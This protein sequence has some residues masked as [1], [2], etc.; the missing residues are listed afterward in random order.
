[1][2]N[3]GNLMPVPAKIS[4]EPGKLRITKQFKIAVQG[5]VSPRLTSG[6]LRMLQR[7]SGR[8][9]L[10]VDQKEVSN[11]MNDSGAELQISCQREGR[12]ELHEDEFYTLKVTAEKAFLSAATDLGVIRGMESF[13]Q[14]LDCDD[15]GFF[16]PAVT[17]ADFPRFPW[18]GLMIDCS[19]HFQPLEVIRR[20]LD[21]MA[22]VKLNVFHWHLSD[23]QGFRVESR[24]CPKLH[25]MGSDQLY[26]TQEQ[27]REII[28]YA[29]ERGIRVV[30][31]FD[32]PGHCTSW[33]VGYPE[34]GSTFQE[35]HIA[36]RYKIFANSIN[37]AK[38]ATYQFLDTFF[39]EMASLFPDDYIHIGG[40]E[41]TDEQWDKDPEIVKFK[42]SNGLETKS[43]LQVYFQNRLGEI[44]AKHHKKMMGWD[45]IL[46]PKLAESSVIESWR[47]KE[48]LVSAVQAGFPCVLANGYYIDL[49]QSAEYHY[50]N[51]PCP[52]KSS[53]NDAQKALILGG[54]AAMWSEY[55]S[56]ENIDSRIWPRTA[57]I[58]ERF[59]SPCDVT[60]VDDMYRRLDTVS[61]HLEELG[62]THEK[63]YLMFLR[64]LAGSYDI[65][66][67][68]NLADVVEPVKEYARHI[69]SQHTTFSPLTR[70]V[71]AA[72]PDAKIA[73]DFRRLIHQM[74]AGTPPDQNKL[75]EAKA[76]LTLWENNH[77][78]LQQTICKAP[79]LKEIADL[80]ADLAKIAAIGLEGLSLIEN[81]KRASKEWVEAKTIFLDEAEKPRGEVELMVVSAVR[82]I[83]RKAG[84]CP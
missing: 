81:Q 69:N 42:K 79:A 48:H 15:Q 38:E 66:A 31:E 70:M 73:R 26:Y 10:F 36:D 49:L 80:A 5:I 27:I 58:A 52:E 34:L 68:K 62:L 12:V 59:W 17:I 37:P 82:Q 43:D 46:D 25:Q 64:R 14:L 57:A 44:L 55:V 77:E 29:A 3:Y 40:D 33:L 60:D 47:G 72:R 21:G 51:D 76:W 45:E 75:N 9:G 35:Y 7:L 74:F 56:A 23:D 50:Q 54:E 63:N 32:L 20:N 2:N 67:L 78:R 16:I 19:R 24:Q 84:G 83:I 18:R 13:L 6:S 8:T 61:L 11:V 22:A 28:S 71:D 39:G 53:L 65:E 41:V 30:P 4:F 1:M